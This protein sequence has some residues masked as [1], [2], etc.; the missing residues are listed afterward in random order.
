[1]NESR[2]REESVGDLLTGECGLLLV[3]L[4]HEWLTCEHRSQ[5]CKVCPEEAQEVEIPSG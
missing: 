3:D 2:E 5:G 1:M 4:P